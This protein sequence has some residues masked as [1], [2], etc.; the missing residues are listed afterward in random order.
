MVDDSKTLK[1]YAVSRPSKTS[2]LVC[3]GLVFLPPL[4]AQPRL[5]LFG[6]RGSSNVFSL[7]CEG[8]GAEFQVEVVE[9]WRLGRDGFALDP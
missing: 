5:P 8:P 3:F 6:L 1:C 9:L 4:P 2:V 7:G